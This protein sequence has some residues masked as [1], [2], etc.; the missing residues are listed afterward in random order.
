MGRKRKTPEFDYTFNQSFDSSES[1]NDKN[2]NCL[3]RTAANNR[4]RARM[5]ILSKA[6]NK[7]KTTL[8]WVCEMETFF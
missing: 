2:L 5:R 7:L 4:E 3:Q 8:P 6:F 1:N